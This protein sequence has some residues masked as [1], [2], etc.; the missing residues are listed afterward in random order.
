MR[1]IFGDQGN[2]ERNF[3]EH[4]NSVKVNL[5]EHLNLFLRNKGTTVNFHREQGNMHPPWEALN[6]KNMWYETVHHNHTRHF[7]VILPTRVFPWIIEEMSVSSIIHGPKFGSS[8]I[9]HEA[10]GF[11][12]MLIKMSVFLVEKNGLDLKFFS[13]LKNV[14]K[15]ELVVSRQPV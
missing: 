7:F 12:F 1:N 8:L 2:M 9:A 4:G 11:P 5:G 3:W 14:F 15:S 10:E 13:R 6:D